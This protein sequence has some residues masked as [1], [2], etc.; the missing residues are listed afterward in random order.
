MRNALVV[1]CEV[2]FVPI[3]KGQPLFGDVDAHL[4]GHGMAF[5][6]FLGMAGRVMKPLVAHG[7]PNFPIQ[8]LWS[9][10]LFVRDLFRLEILDAAQLLKFAVLCDLYDSKDVALHLLRRYDGI[11]GTALGDVYVMVL[12]AAGP[13][14]SLSAGSQAQ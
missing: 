9:D 3:Y 14:K 8:F 11:Q 4:R 5:H 12:D 2:E 13:W 1:V 10:A 7:S 6:K